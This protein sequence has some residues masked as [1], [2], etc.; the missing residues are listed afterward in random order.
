MKDRD[1]N[2]RDFVWMGIALTLIL[3]VVADAN[4]YNPQ[5]LLTWAICTA[6]LAPSTKS[7]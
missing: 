4:G 1:L 3:A 5:I 2:D 7:K 6:I